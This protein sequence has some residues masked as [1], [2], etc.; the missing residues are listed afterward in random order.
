MHG[1]SIYQSPRVLTPEQRKARDA[2]RKADAEVALR[3]RAAAEKAFHA[4][5]ERLRAA[6][7]A[8]ELAEEAAKNAPP[9]GRK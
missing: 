6:R 4:N 8:R 7:L 9:R 5:R 3:E 1:D 2:A